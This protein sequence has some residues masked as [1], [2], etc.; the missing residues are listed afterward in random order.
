MSN[1]ISFFRWFLYQPVQNS[2]II[3]EPSGSCRV[4]GRNPK[5]SG[6]RVYGVLLR[7]EPRPP[8]NSESQPSHSID[9]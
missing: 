9:L 2:K 6:E 1:N 8:H 5:V 3:S 7:V 4:S